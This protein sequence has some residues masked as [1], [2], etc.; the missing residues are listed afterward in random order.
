MKIEEILTLRLLKEQ[1]ELLLK[2]LEKE[3]I[4]II[5]KNQI[6]IDITNWYYKN[7]WPNENYKLSC[8]FT[9]LKVNRKYKKK[10][11]D[12]KNRI[13]SRYN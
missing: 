12:I 9:N 3:N 7:R 13:I 2:E 6:L 8:N 10:I 1:K 5:I 4:K 11:K